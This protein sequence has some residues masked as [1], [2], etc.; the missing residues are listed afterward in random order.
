MM[1]NSD[2]WGLQ[3]VRNLATIKMASEG[4]LTLGVATG[5]TECCLEQFKQKLEVTKAMHSKIQ[6]C[7]DTQIE[8]VLSKLCLGTNKVNHILRVHVQRLWEKGTTIR[9]FDEC[10]RGTLDRLFPSLTIIV[11]SRQLW[12]LPWAVWAENQLGM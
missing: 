2:A 11:I 8:H 5:G 4:G 7:E 1:D 10:L 9:Q 6:I 3:D 12:A